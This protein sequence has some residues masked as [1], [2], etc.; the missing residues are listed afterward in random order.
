MTNRGTCGMREKKRGN[1]LRDNAS[2]AR[3]DMP[4]MCT[5]KNSKSK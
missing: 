4:G 5:A 3:L 1:E 2:A